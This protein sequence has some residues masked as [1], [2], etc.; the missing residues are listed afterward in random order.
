M[1]RLPEQMAHLGRTN[2]PSATVDAALPPWT[3]QQDDEPA[4][5]DDDAP[6][7]PSAVEVMFVEAISAIPTQPLL[8]HSPRP[9]PHLSWQEGMET[10]LSLLLILGSI[11]GI[12]WG[13]LTYPG[14]TV[15]LVPVTQ[16]S[17]LITRLPAVPLRQLPAVRLIQN[18]TTT[19]SGTGYQPAVAAAGLLTF[20]NGALVAQ[21]VTQGTVLTGQDGVQVALI[22]SITIPPASPPLF[23]QTSAPARAV[24]P[25]TYG[26]IAAGDLNEACCAPSLLVKNLAPFVGGQEARTFR[27]VA[28]RDLDRLRTR[29]LATLLQQLP[30]AFARR[31]GEAVVLT[32]TTLTS[33]ASRRVGEEASMVTVM[34]TLIG[35]GVA[36]QSATL[37]TQA[38]AA[39][40][41]QA[42]PGAHYRLLDT[43][44]AA[45]I[46]RVTPLLVACRG[47]WVYRLS[48]TY[49]DKLTRQIAG[50]SAKQAT[51]RLLQSGV[52]AQAIVP[53]SLP[54]DPQS[55]HFRVTLAA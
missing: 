49:L 19:T 10:L 20:Y 15:T 27:A 13:I 9:I 26:N 21:S 50:L 1:T 16:K 18:A 5:D 41:A 52:I 4:V 24:L 44:V 17:S 25:G 14:V 8:L 2:T 7:T 39:L 46:M 40:R 55:I 34:M 33:R 3:E 29:L 32:S 48:E 12:V 28:A 53:G 23:G 6:L 38:R 42:S 43:S 54:N 35:H 37:L 31:R 47:E 22:A 30:M 51:A 11:A 45:T 36:Y